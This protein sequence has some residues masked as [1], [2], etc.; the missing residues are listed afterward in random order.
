MAT[1][2][3]LSD[4]LAITQ[5]LTAA[6]D[7]MAKSLARV[8]SSY[9]SQIASVE[10]LTKAIETLTSQDLSKLNGIKLERAKKELEDTEKQ[11]TSLSGRLK[12]LGQN[13]TKK[14]PVAVGVAL[15]ALS[16][17]K[18]GVRN[19]VA[20]GK[21]V[22]GFF[23]S[24]I[25]GAADIAA[26]IIAIPFKMFNALVDT[27]AAAGAG[28]NELAVA[29]EKI[30][31]EFGDLKG[32]VAHTIIETTK[33]MKGFSETGL[34]T[35]RIFG[36]MAERLEHVTKI[37]SSMG[38]TF[39]LMTD[40]FKQNGG[41]LLAFE[42]GL[43]GSGEGMKQIAERAIAMGKPMTKVFMD[44]T[45][46]TLALGKAFDIDQK[47]IGKDMVKA[48][49]DVKHFGQ[50]TVKE[51]GTA[52]VYARKLGVE[53]DKITGTLDAFE[54]FDTAAENASKLS[55]SFGLTVDAFKL[56]EAQNPA[57][58]ID[59]LRKSMKLAGVSTETMTRQ[60]LKLLSQTTGLDEATAKLAFSSKNEGV[61]LD[62]IKKKSAE[63]EK[64]TLT[65]AQAMG[66]LADSIE[67]LV[68]SGQ[69]QEGGFWQ[70]F[71]KGFLGGIQS[72]KEFRDIIWN[73]KKSL[74]AT[75]IEGVRL[76]KAFVNLFPGVKTFLAGIGDFFKPE[77]FKKLTAG[78]T[79]VLIDWM[80]DLSD[81]NGKAS[82]SSLMDKLQKKFFDFFDSNTQTGQKM[83]GGLK[84]MMKT[85]AKI[86]SEGIKWAA[87]K[88]AVG[89]KFIVDLL[90]GKVDLSKIGASVGGGVGFMA[91][92]LEPLGKSLVHAWEVLKDP[93]RKLVGTILTKLKDILIEEAKKA[94]WE[95]WAGLA[96]AV[97][98]PAI[99]RA[100]LGAIT[101]KAVGGIITGVGKML[102]GKAVTTAAEQ[103]A[104]QLAKSTATSV[105]T[106]LE[107]ELASAAPKAA[108]G[109]AARVGGV[110]TSG[111]T[112][113][114]SSLSTIAAGS[115][116]TVAAA[117]A[118]VVASAVGGFF[119]G[120]AITDALEDS[121]Q[122][123]EKSVKGSADELF[124][125]MT[126]D[127]GVA[128]KRAELERQ[129]TLLEQNKK[130]LKDRWAI[131][132]FWEEMG[133]TDD[134]TQE[135]TLARTEEFIKAQDEQLKKQESQAKKMSDAAAH[136]EAR[137]A[138]RTSSVN[139]L[140]ANSVDDAGEKLKKLQ[141]LATQMNGKGFNVEE[142]LDSVKKKF[143][144]INFTIFDEE[145]AKQV[146]GLSDQ[147]DSL[148][149]VFT[150]LDA[151]SKALGTLSH[152][153][154][155]D[156]TPVFNQID[157]AIFHLGALMTNVD[158]SLKSKDMM[159][160]IN[161]RLSSLVDSLQDFVKMSDATKSLATRDI[162][163]EFSTTLNKVKASV[164]KIVASLD[165]QS[166]LGAADA[167]DRIRT[168]AKSLDRVN[169]TISNGGIGLAL[170]AVGTMI[171]KTQEL[172]NALAQAPNMNVD[173][174]LKKLANA[175]G[176]GGKFAYTVKSKDVVI[177][178]NL[179][180]SMDVGEVEKVMI[181]RK[182]SIIRDRLEFATGS[183]THGQAAQ[184]QIPEKFTP[185]WNV[186]STGK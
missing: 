171:K 28:M 60:Q 26:S 143:E 134:F 46:Q 170:S 109:I 53:L 156:M 145:K 131:T 29:I 149:G 25:S 151:V 8:E 112:L 96:F 9:D 108:T 43:D 48:L 83:L 49:A 76:G 11:V 102:A 137:K 152:V 144:K 62:Q 22:T 99:G 161:V 59:L 124:K 179:S 180:V 125:T 88:L 63:A 42:K 33:T 119:A 78:V 162:G 3:E 159:Q 5:K 115:A 93:L 68:K 133:R 135:K 172:D 116:A 160:N 110:L 52:S 163:T 155:P 54:T 91:E 150:G 89:I 111:M 4:Q 126:S 132:K 84:T 40:E 157:D 186:S 178:L 129:K 121:V 90:T 181:M 175:T 138:A 86:V 139:F 39:G 65:Q 87:D 69:T 56:M 79:N 146:D 148:V 95:M 37:A 100:L 105:A 31:K 35:F 165:D 30:R 166:I 141:A 127:I 44:M 123:T 153:K 36:T 51:I 24:F 13:M 34:S 117:G 77:K 45:K 73:I 147:V 122:T 16:G 183:D 10:K 1:K 71:F 57:D 114:G 113:A 15:A 17:L 2:E 21:S 104:S 94:P 81:P 154:L 136:K 177:N 118:A 70:M 58:Q 75:Y 64:K 106:S 182:T 72:S 47:L 61:S 55:Q 107:G 97:I 38:A 82:F 32:P 66:K 19:V 120:K 174:R 67:R 168:Y 92:I 185:G 50:L 173:A 14:F 27:A 164:D 140:G 85:M 128:E 7:Q 130:A 6:V 98:G 12:D 18:Q 103:A 80:K 176:I 184:T 169:D 158:Q 101:Q 23:T 74:Q 167:E 20:L 41:A 142:I